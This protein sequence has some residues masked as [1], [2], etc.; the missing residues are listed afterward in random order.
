M[1]CLTAKNNFIYRVK[2]GESLDL[3][4]QNYLAIRVSSETQ[5][6]NELYWCH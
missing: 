4:A 6:R 3:I 2:L 5:E 1:L